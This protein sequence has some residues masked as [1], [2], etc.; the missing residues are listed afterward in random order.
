[1]KNHLLL[2]LF[3]FIGLPNWYCSAHVQGAGDTFE[4][5][6]VTSKGAWCW[7]ADPRAIHYES[8]DGSI[9]KTYIG[10]I[11]VHGNIKAMQIDRKTN[12]KEEVLIRSW[13]QPDDHNNPTFLV[14]PDERVMVF[15]SRHTDE[16]CFYYRVSRE[17]GDITTLGEEKII[18]TKNNTTYPSPFILSDDPKH[19]YLCWRGIN[20]HPTIGRLLVPDAA[21]DTNFDWG[22]YQIV[23][24]TGARPYAKYTSNGK[25][26]ICMTYTTG[27]PDN[28]CPNHVY[29]NEIDINSLKLKDVKGQVLAT[30]QDS[31]HHVNAKSEY[32]TAY[33]NAVVDCSGSRDWVWE[34]ALD[35]K[36]QPIIAM[37][38]ISADKTKH[39]YYY[40]NWNGQKWNT[41]FLADAGGHFHQTPDTERCYS[42]GMA[43]SKSNVTEVYGSV[44]VTGKYGTVYEIMKFTVKADGTIDRKAVTHNSRKNNARPYFIFGAE[45]DS[46]CLT[47][48]YGNYYDWIVSEKRP[49]GYCT[50]IHAIVPLPGSEKVDR[51]KSLTAQACTDDFKRVK[52]IGSTTSNNFTLS[53]LLEGMK[54]L[55]GGMLCSFG[56][57]AYGIDNRTRKPFLLVNDCYLASTNVLGTSDGW[58]QY[59]R[60][61]DGKWQEPVLPHTLNL[62][63]TYANGVLNT[64]VNGLLDQSVFVKDTCAKKVFLTRMKKGDNPIWFKLY[65]RK[66]SQEEIKQLNIN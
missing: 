45:K 65:D 3:L 9:N 17:P 46:L 10:Y 8:K 23:Q 21:G 56:N 60:S 27:H 53:L 40:A 2:L 25:D 48:M 16:P 12:R 4:G 7:F 13:F 50:A 1:M 26:K 42:G 39:S 63:I 24:S 34:T 57:V 11:D 22:P 19:I 20:W 37:V 49:Q 52:S 33:P 38:R 51:T 58:R 54:Q 66:L 14:L 44:P 64:Y 35:A 59:K 15:Y 30:I 61:T 28:E 29:Y 6:E 62:C 55:P 5:Y 31:P 18:K 32:R 43:I 41:T 47:W 36:G